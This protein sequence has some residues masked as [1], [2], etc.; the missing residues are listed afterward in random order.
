MSHRI[1]KFPL[2]RN[3]LAVFRGIC[4]ENLE[5]WILSSLFPYS[6]MKQHKKISVGY[7]MFN[8]RTMFSNGHNVFHLRK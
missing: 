3:L 4:F 7:E 6:E 1:A 8:L 5:F 2:W